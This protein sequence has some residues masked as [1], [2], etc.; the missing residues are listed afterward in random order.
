MAF[1]A[2][3][4]NK[5]KSKGDSLKVIIDES[6]NLTV[7]GDTKIRFHSTNSVSY[8]LSMFTSCQLV[9][10]ASFRC[11][12]DS[13]FNTRPVLTYFFVFILFL[14]VFCEYN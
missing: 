1:N 8:F 6:V 7:V 10:E 14:L 9:L 5:L 2:P 11:F 3:E 12:I 13:A 4:S